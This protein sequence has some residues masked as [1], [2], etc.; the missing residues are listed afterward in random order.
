MQLEQRSAPYQPLLQAFDGFVQEQL[1]RV[2]ELA[3]RAK[4]MTEAFWCG[5]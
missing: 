1:E 4:K 3:V 5:N 2:S